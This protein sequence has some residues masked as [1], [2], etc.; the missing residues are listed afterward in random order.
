MAEATTAGPAASAPDAAIRRSGVGGDGSRGGKPPAPVS[1]R[2][3]R[4]VFGSP[5]FL[6]PALLVL[7]AL[8]MYL[9][10]YTIWR[11]LFDQSGDSFVGIDNYQEMFSRGDTRTAIRNNVIWVVVAPPW[12]PASA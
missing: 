10:G 6:L 5:A 8:V 1:G 12:P 9:I 7:G 11:S 2:D 4:N 3:W